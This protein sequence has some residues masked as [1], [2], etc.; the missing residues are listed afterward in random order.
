MLCQTK[1]SLSNL[2]KMRKNKNTLKAT[3]TWLNNWQT[4]ETE[5]KVN[6]KSE[7]HEHE[8]LEEKGDGVI[9]LN[10]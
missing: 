7:E 1:T 4:C 3:Q 5:R 9:L 8:Q 6:P 2:K 10:I